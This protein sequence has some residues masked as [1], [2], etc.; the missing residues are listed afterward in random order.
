MSNEA[1]LDFLQDD[2]SVWARIARR[3]ESDAA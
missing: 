2:S 1:L 3:P